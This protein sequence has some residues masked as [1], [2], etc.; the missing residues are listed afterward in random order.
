MTPRE[1][2]SGCPLA[3]FCCGRQAD[4]RVMRFVYG[5]VTHSVVLRRAASASSG[6]LLETQSQAPPQSYQ[7]RICILTRFP[8]LYACLR[9]RSGG[10]RNLPEILFAAIELTISCSKVVSIH[11]TLPVSTQISL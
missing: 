9:L 5:L 2:T 11:F 4:L 6:S 8:G 7:I 10:L 3:V 1:L